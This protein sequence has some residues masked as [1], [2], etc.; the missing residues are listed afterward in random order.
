MLSSIIRKRNT[1]TPL[2]PIIY[3][4]LIGVLW[5]TNIRSLKLSLILVVLLGAVVFFRH[6]RPF[7]RDILPIV[8]MMFAYEAMRGLVVDLGWSVHITELF[9]TERRLF[10]TIPSADLQRLW[11]ATGIYHWYDYTLALFYGSFYFIPFVVGITL[12]VKRR[13]YYYFYINGLVL[14]TLAGYVTYIV[15]PAMPPW[16]ASEQGYFSGVTKMIIDLSQS[17][18]GIHLPSLYSALGANQVAAMPSIH[19]AWPWYSFLCL[20]YLYRW[21]AAWSLVVPVG[22]WLA[23]VYLGEHYIIDVI[24]GIVYATAAFLI[25]FAFRNK[26]LKPAPLT[27]AATTV[28]P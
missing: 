12:W 22:I 15:Y 11:H 4:G 5:L 25:M 14:L 20:I 27:H 16:M 24:A 21:R 19:S 2:T 6:S 8:M 23:V 3:S 7:V 9:N 18:L 26:I 10:G 13:D 17:G 1:P 28:T